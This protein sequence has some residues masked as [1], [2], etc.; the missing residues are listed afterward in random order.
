[1]STNYRWVQILTGIYSFRGLL[2][3]LGNMA[4]LQV[5][6][7]LKSDILQPSQPSKSLHKQTE[8]C[9][10]QAT[11]TQKQILCQDENAFLFT[12]GNRTEWP[13]LVV[14]RNAMKRMS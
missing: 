3:H 12:V 10:T 1:M 5:L 8:A 13:S 4:D 9:D 6:S 7:A 11:E 2:C 14:F